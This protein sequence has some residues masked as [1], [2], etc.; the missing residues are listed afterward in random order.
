ML[1]FIAIPVG[2]EWY[3]IARYLF[4]DKARER[5]DSGLRDPHTLT[6]PVGDMLFWHLDES[7]K[8][9]TQV[10]NIGAAR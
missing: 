9:C 3:A 5:I 4:F 6:P 8:G 2:R 7:E 10:A 1:E